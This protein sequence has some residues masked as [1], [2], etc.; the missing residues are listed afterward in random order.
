MPLLTPAPMRSQLCLN[1]WRKN[2]SLPPRK[3]AKLWKPDTAGALGI[4]LG[5]M[6]DN[7]SPRNEILRTSKRVG[8]T[9][10]RRW[11]GYHPRSRAETRMHCVKLL[12]QCLSAHEFY[13]Q[14]A[15]FQIP[16]AVRNGFTAHGIPATD[17]VG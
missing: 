12:G 8:R 15:E 16:V 5:P 6:A 4:V 17:A 2:G 14:V 11:S 13:R 7:A 10:S 9:I 1:Q 3:N